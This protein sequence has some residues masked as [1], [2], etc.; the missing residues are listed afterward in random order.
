MEDLPSVENAMNYIDILYNSGNEEQKKQA[1]EWNY[2]Q[3]CV[4][5][6]I[7]DDLQFYNCKG[8]FK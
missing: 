2:K 1:S 7:I 3:G 8:T 4:V 5:F 6:V